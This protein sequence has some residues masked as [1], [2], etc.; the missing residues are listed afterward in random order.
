MMTGNLTGCRIQLKV[1]GL[2]TKQNNV[3]TNIDHLL[4]DRWSSIVGMTA[5]FGAL[6]Q[7]GGECLSRAV[8]K[9]H[10]TVSND[11]R[12]CICWHESASSWLSMNLCSSHLQA[13]A[14]VA[15]CVWGATCQA[16]SGY[17]APIV[18]PGLVVSSVP[19]ACHL[20]GCNQLVCCSHCIHHRY[21]Y[22]SSHQSF[23][24]YEI[25]ST[26]QTSKSGYQTPYATS[27][28]G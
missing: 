21:H 7:A 4:S 8:W 13:I 3:S 12:S 6:T 27:M 23:S 1:W 9:L 18:P 22:H 5:C 10:L 24:A 17:I 20:T 16:C 28:P 14:C 26:L 15:A 19:L 11:A 2:F 25:C